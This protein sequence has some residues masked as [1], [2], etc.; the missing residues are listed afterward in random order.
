MDISFF[1]I[2][3]LIISLFLFLALI[4]L[5]KQKNEIEVS[6]K[7]ERLEHLT[8][9]EHNYSDL[10]KKYR[11]LAER[12]GEVERKKE[13]I[14]SELRTVD[15][16]A[17]HIF[18]LNKNLKYIKNKF[19]DLHIQ[20]RD[21][22][23]LLGETRQEIESELGSYKRL[24][25][26]FDRN[27]QENSKILTE[28]IDYIGTIVKQTQ[29]ATSLIIDDEFTLELNLK[30][31]SINSLID[32]LLNKYNVFVELKNIKFNKNLFDLL[33]ETKI[34]PHK[35]GEAFDIILNNII[36]FAEIG[37]TIK[38]STGIKEGHIYLEVSDKSNVFSE[39][40]IKR[41]FNKFE[42]NDIFSDGIKGFN[43]YLVKKIVEEHHGRITLTNDLKS[44]STFNI[45]LPII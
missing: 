10:E 4:I 9:E 33:P 42:Q 12:I 18:L 14:Y 25:D 38:I 32:T 31:Y 21:L 44:G 3:I 8:Q 30:K 28:I 35:M 27:S 40:D 26:E 16:S 6:Y 37:T 23:S 15:V 34:D 7:K 22:S 20:K 5:L 17:E 39:Q 24:V 1:E 29:T 19:N 11:E 13:S 36:K 45:Q 2:L 43:L 41:A